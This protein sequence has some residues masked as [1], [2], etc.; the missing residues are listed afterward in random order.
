[1]G[2]FGKPEINIILRTGGIREK[3]VFD[4]PEPV[5][6][7]K[8]QPHNHGNGNPSELYAFGEKTLIDL[9]EFPAIGVFG[10]PSLIRVNIYL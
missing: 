5:Y 2:A 10:F 6:G 3:A 7:K 1:M 9:V 8:K 4:E